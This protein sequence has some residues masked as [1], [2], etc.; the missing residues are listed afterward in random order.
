MHGSDDVFTLHVES[1]ALERRSA[2][3]LSIQK[4]TINIFFLMFI[5]SFPFL[6]Q[7]FFRFELRALLRR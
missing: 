2:G 6:F 3:E 4:C 5:H 1:I 7:S